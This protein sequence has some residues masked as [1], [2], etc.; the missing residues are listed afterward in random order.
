[1]LFWTG[2]F[3]VPVL[4]AEPVERP[5]AADDPVNLPPAAAGEARAAPARLYDLGAGYSLTHN[6][7]ITRGTTP[8][9]GCAAPPCAE[10]TQQIFAGITYEE[11]SAALNARLTG[12]VER[13]RFLNDVYQDDTGFFADGAGIWTIV[14][15]HFTWSLEDSFRE[16]PI[17]LADPDTPENRVKANSFSTGPEFSFRL[18]SG[19]VPVIGARYGR[20]DIEEIETL[21]P[22]LVDSERYTLYARWLRLV[23][24]VTTLSL[25]YEGSRVDFD[26]PVPPVAQPT[27]F[28]QQD[29]F[30]RY[31]LVLPYNRQMLDL[32]ATR[33]VQYG[34]E[35]LNRPELNRPL[36][37]YFGQLSSRAESALRLTLYD[38]V[39]DTYSD[40][41]RNV[42]SLTIPTIPTTPAD[43][44]AFSGTSGAVAAD[45]YESRGGELILVDLRGLLA[46]SLQGYVRR[47]DYLN[48]SQDYEEKGGRASV[49]LLFSTSTQAYA[50]TQYRRRNFSFSGEED[51]DRDTR[52]GL[53][54]RLG[55]SFT[56]TAEAGRMERESTS[57]ANTYVDRQAMLVLGY[58][59]GPLYSARS[60]R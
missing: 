44:V 45:I 30:L 7:N 34:N 58:S 36:I 9:P 22:G 32:G 16:V 1:L 46:Y 50:F 25:N 8:T 39:S 48:L 29:L 57:P 15:R 2:T 20:Y 31:E 59:T 4:A 14:P 41:I 47:I 12:Q 53:I 52:L 35:A 13:R 38:Q 3:G 40:M 26:H 6:S 18:G 11:R 54:Y 21:E 17:D 23:S 55:R 49:T 37:R 19:N 43:A 42:T 27:R 24:P 5:A 56:L 33:V 60:R 28:S 51:A 10:T